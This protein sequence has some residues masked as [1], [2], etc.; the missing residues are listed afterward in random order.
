MSVFDEANPRRGIALR[1]TCGDHSVIRLPR[2]MSLRILPK[3]GMTEIYNSLVAR[4][5]VSKKSLVRGESKRIYGD[6]E[7]GG[8]P[9][10]C[11]VGVQVL[12][13]G[14]VAQSSSCSGSLSNAHWKV[15]LKMTRR[16]EVALESFADTSILRQLSVAKQVVPFRTMSTPNASADVKYFGA[17][18][19]GQNVFLRCHTDD[20]FTMSVT[21]IFLKG[22]DCYDVHDNVVAFFC[23]PTRGLA[24]PMR[25]GDFVLFDATLPH[26]VSSR[27][28]YSDD[29]M[30]VTYYLKSK[31][32]GM[33]DNSIP[34]S[35]EQKHLSSLYSNVLIHP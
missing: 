19:F 12:R 6:G 11:S 25:P 31:V 13:T 20:D 8:S 32:V 4:E 1:E 35:M 2:L 22:I 24:V 28:H 34:L 33:N 16:A 26:C 15:I 5:Y 3:S 21:Q 23:F 14:G 17:I 29:I 10:S 30:C 18:A 27:C 7:N 9:F